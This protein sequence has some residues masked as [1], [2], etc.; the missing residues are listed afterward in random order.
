ME[1]REQHCQAGESSVSE[2]GDT[3]DEVSFFLSTFIFLFNFFNATFCL[4]A[5]ASSLLSPLANLKLNS[6]LGLWSNL[7][8][9]STSI[10]R[11][12][13]LL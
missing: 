8:P 2:T 12:V 4:F 3:N 7:C 13:S 10:L 6:V 1:D 9:K 5:R 11:V